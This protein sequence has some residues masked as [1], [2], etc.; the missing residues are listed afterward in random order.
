MAIGSQAR[1]TLE[2]LAREPAKVE[3]IGGTIVRLRPTGRKPNRVAGRIFRILDDHAEQSGRGEAFTDNMGF[4]VPV[5]PSGR[6]SFAPNAAYYVGPPPA[7]AMR[8]IEGPPTLAVEV[9]SQTDHGP[10]AEEAMAAK[11]R[12]ISRPAPWSSG[13]STRLPN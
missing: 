9:R 1:E 7:D 6:Q 10:L 5:L 4:T 3:L 13:T 12:A 8:F 2:D 11:R